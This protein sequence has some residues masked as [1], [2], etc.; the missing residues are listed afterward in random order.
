MDFFYKS[1]LSTGVDDICPKTGKPSLQGELQ[2]WFDAIATHDPFI[3]S[4]LYE[5]SAV[6]LPTFRRKIHK[7]PIERLEYFKFFM[8]FKA[9]RGVVDE[10]HPQIIG[11]VGVNSGL[12][13]FIFE[14]DGVEKIVYARFTFSYIFEDNSWKLISHHSSALPEN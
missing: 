14:E 2:K 1:S 13:H 4:T 11:D 8:A 3:V 5:T 6:L 9:L 7:T 10:Q 12:Y